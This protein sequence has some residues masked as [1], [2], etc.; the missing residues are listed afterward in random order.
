MPPV[1][2]SPVTNFELAVIK[3]FRSSVSSASI[4]AVSPEVPP[5]I[6]SPF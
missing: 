1:I 2:V 3:I 6:V 5:V 4:V